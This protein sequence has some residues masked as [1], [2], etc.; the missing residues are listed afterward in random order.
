VSVAGLKL[1]GGVNW[2]ECIRKRV[3]TLRCAEIT[4]EIKKII[5]VM[6]FYT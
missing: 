5:Q 1:L 3:L 4:L 2:D 6:S